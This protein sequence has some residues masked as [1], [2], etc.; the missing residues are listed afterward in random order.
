MVTV[1]L[2]I[3]SLT[4]LLQSQHHL[5]LCALQLLGQGEDF[6]WLGVIDAL[7]GVGAE[8]MVVC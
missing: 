3:A 7:R 6:L 8:D 4:G 2:G 5:T 1:K